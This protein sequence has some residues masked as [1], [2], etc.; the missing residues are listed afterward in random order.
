M[1]YEK[2][3]CLVNE[4]K[5]EFVDFS[6]ESCAKLLNIY[7]SRMEDCQLKALLYMYLK[8]NKVCCELKI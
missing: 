5:E 1:S 2:L 6:K 8:H 3:D 4:Y 7:M